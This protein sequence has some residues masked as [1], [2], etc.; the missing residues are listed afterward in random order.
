MLILKGLDFRQVFIL[1]GLKHIVPVLVKLLVLVKVSVFA[2]L[3]LLLVVEDHFLHLARV[4]LLFQFLDTIRS[5]LSLYVSTFR[6]TH[7]S[8][9]LHSDTKLNVDGYHK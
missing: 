4:L 8:V 7:C 5:H 3:T 6:L 1:S 9:I 2:L